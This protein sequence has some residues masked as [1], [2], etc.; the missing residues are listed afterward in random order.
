MPPN[1]SPP[2]AVPASERLQRRCG[3]ERCIRI[4]PRPADALADA[5]ADARQNISKC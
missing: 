3:Q 4:A 5:L 1:A 2:G